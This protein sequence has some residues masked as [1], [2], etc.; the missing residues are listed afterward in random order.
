MTTPT[1]FAVAPFEHYMLADDFDRY[2]MTANV[3]FW[4]DGYFDRPT[5]EAAL[6]IVLAEHPLFQVFLRGDIA[7]RTKNLRWYHPGQVT[8]P[9]IYWAREPFTTS[10]AGYTFPGGS[11]SIDLHNEI[12]L[13]LFVREHDGRTELTVTF[14]HATSDGKGVFNF[15]EDLI[16]AYGELRGGRPRAPRTGQELLQ[17]RAFFGLTLGERLARMWRDMIVLW[18][19]F[20]M[21]PATLSG[22][23][24]GK[25]ILS[26]APQRSDIYR[27]V[28]RKIP[29]DTI[30]RVKLTANA[31]GSTLNDILLRDLFMTLGA[32]NHLAGGNS[33]ATR[34]TVAVPVCMRGAR[35]QNTSASNYVSMHI[36]HVPNR[37]LQHP[38]NL[39]RHIHKIMR[40]VKSFEMGHTLVVF[41]MLAGKIPGGLSRFFQIPLS[42]ATAVLTNLGVPYSDSPLRDGPGPIRFADMTLTGVETLPP[43]RD[44][45]R[46]GISINSY[47]GDLRVTMRYD[48]TV[49]DEAAAD[50]LV[51]KFVERVGL[52]AAEADLLPAPD[53]APAKTG[54]P[55][56]PQ[57]YQ[58]A[59]SP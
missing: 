45:T 22:K 15:G 54:L 38:G 59:P 11:Q 47:D 17:E 50:R 58:T 19:F 27:I 13:R 6:R 42:R 30:A 9:Y 32:W 23:S 4:F 37:V 57:S 43:V 53:R 18:K 36:L 55:S 12:G 7:G 56:Q 20:T 35:F 31:N 16:A 8:M 25:P 21:I 26:A 14:H 3:R 24:G 28:R 51:D 48:D 46:V 44:R 39:L 5:F 2:S 52:T 41:A 49:F 29:R 40:F 33:P 10:G 1:T 34:V